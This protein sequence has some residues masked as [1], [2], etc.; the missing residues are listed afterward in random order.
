MLQYNAYY[1]TG[2]SLI[3]SEQDIV[4]CN[5]LRLGCEGGH[6]VFAFNYAHDSGVALQQM[7]PYRNKQVACERT[8]KNI[9]AAYVSPG[10]D[11]LSLLIFSNDL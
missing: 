9:T 8:K 2:K 3:L 7:Y 4:D 11:F 5:V 10:I 1:E 6:F